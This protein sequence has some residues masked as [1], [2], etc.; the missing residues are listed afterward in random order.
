[1]Q[2]PKEPPT[3]LIVD[4]EPANTELLEAFLEDEGYRLH[5]TNDPRDVLGLCQAIRPD[6]LLLD[7]HMP[8]LDGFSVMR[9][10]R[11]LTPEDVYFPVLV[12]TADVS[13]T[14]K[15]RAL[16]GGA[17]DFLLKPLDAVEVQ[18]R[19]RNLLETRFLHERQ[20]EARLAAEAA[21]RR[22]VLLGE[23]SHL[24]GSSLDSSTTLSTLARFL[25]PQ[26]A[27]YCAI[28]L[29]GD[30]GHGH[31]DVR[32]VA[33]VDPELEARLR[34]GLSPRGPSANPLL[35][36]L[37][38]TEGTVLE[39][40]EDEVLAEAAL[41]MD[42]GEDL[43]AMRP[44][45]LICVPLQASQ[46]TV[47]GMVLVRSD[48][49]ARFTL[50]DFRLVEELARRATLAIENARLFHA[51]QLALRARDQVLAVVAHDLRNPLSTVTMGSGML[52]ESLAGSEYAGEQRYVHVI[53]RAAY[54][55][56]TLIQDLL[57]ATRIESG[58]L[59]IDAHPEPLPHLL[60][61][62]V[63]MHRLGATAEGVNLRLEVA[64]GLPPMHI[65]SA[66]VQ[67]VLSNLIGNALKFTP[68][69][70]EITVRADPYG[71]GFCVVSVVDTG[72]G[73]A[74]EQLPHIFGRFWQ[75]QRTDRRGIGLG[76]AIAKGIVEAHGGEIWVESELGAGSRFCF[77]LRFAT[78]SP[79]LPSSSNV[80]LPTS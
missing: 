45:S 53:Q 38:T 63:E 27:D 4:D 12:L 69:G 48:S 16:A 64:D 55:M 22:A 40:I 10:V 33:H 8:F 52:L 32:G 54:R 21:E 50:E 42:N 30:D 34:S 29:D 15:E 68:T 56:E 1:M 28:S 25:V 35:E 20:R 41:G 36:A 9:Q 47:G 71:D 78:P 73:I 3:V 5:S 49:R 62:A 2:Q 39:E 66:R 77:T 80:L 72:P 59:S 43:L 79:H 65:D 24:L 44:R 7:L 14:M 76:L 37:Q 74:P 57:D 67:Q 13:D 18:L 6:L 19:I 23:A 17:K 58:N 61:E 51:A 60:A 11:E 75:A 31:G 46:A 26:L 70:G